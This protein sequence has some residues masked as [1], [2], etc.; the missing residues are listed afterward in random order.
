MKVS[1]TEGVV[2][3]SCDCVS[4]DR[5]SCDC[6]GDTDRAVSTVTAPAAVVLSSLT[7]C[8]V[9]WSRWTTARASTSQRVT[10]TRQMARCT[11]SRTN[12][13]GGAR[14][15]VAKQCFILSLCDI[16]V[17][18]CVVIPVQSLYGNVR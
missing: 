9:T 3:E 13:V 8:P 11:A 1:K 7:N 4:C 14:S 15:T 5:V 12:T 17:Y 16:C 18:D 2:K 10:R 6:A